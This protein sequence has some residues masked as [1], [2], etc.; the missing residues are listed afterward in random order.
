MTSKPWTVKEIQDA[1]R[2]YY[3]GG[4]AAVCK[5]LPHRTRAAIQTQAQL[6]KW[7]LWTIINEGTI[8]SKIVEAASAGPVTAYDVA[9]DLG[10]NIKSISAIMCQLYRRKVLFRDRAE[11]PGN[12]A[13]TFKYTVNPE[14]IEAT[15]Q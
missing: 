2:V 6:G 10:V 1:K 15:K 7:P 3:T 9:S 14:W 8:A 4:S 12:G 11:T 13:L 5:L